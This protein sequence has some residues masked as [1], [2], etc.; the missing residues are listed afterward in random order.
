MSIAGAQDTDDPEALRRELAAERARLEE[1]MKRLDELEARLDAAI[2]E[3]G[4]APE[5]AATIEG[6]EVAAGSDNIVPERLDDG[7]ESDQG[8]A[9]GHYRRRS[10]RT[11][12]SWGR[13]RCSAPITG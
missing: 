10:W 4:A 7:T 6:E 3:E 11:T 2:A 13:G 5:A 1:Q 8:R 9:R 12:I